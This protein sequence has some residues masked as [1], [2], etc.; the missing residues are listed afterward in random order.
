MNL[1]LEVNYGKTNWELKKL[2]NLSIKEQL[3]LY[4]SFF[5]NAIQILNNYLIRDISDLITNYCGRE[6]CEEIMMLN[7][8]RSRELSFTF[9]S[10]NT[11]GIS[12]QS[13]KICTFIDLFPTNFYIRN[14]NVTTK[15]LRKL[16]KLLQFNQF[17]KNKFLNYEDMLKNKCD[18]IEE[19]FKKAQNYHQSKEYNNL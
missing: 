19:L 16:Y 3:K 1:L 13:Q 12:E 7:E 5:N 4:N 2:N 14:F 6:K 18:S 11:L 17:I 8:W 9:S 10:I 15:I